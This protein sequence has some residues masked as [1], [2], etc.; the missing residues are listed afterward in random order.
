MEI[1]IYVSF[2]TPTIKANNRDWVNDVRLKSLQV[3]ENLKVFEGIPVCIGTYRS[4]S[5]D[6]A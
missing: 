3:C 5:L 2:Q 1:L 6:E 4:H